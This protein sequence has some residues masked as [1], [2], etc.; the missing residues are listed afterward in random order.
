MSD[1]SDRRKETRALVV[2]FTLIF[3]KQKGK[4][5]GYLRDLT[6]SGAQVNGSKAEEVG[7]EVDLSIE[8]PHDLAGVSQ[9]QLHLKAKVA[10]CAEVTKE[11]PDY[12]VGFV[13]TEIPASERGVV[14]KLVQ[15]FAARRSWTN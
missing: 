6:A 3:D 11:P 2:E 4:L 8:L 9:E 5:L 15:R 12:V 7:T 14:D 10:H 1:Y 13:F